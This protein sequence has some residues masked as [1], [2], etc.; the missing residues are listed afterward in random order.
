VGGDLRSEI[1]PVRSSAIAPTLDSAPAFDYESGPMGW[2]HDL[3]RWIAALLILAFFVSGALA[4]LLVTRL[5]SQRR[6][7]HALVDN[8]V[9][10]WIFSATLAI[11]AITVGLTAVASWSNAVAASNV[12]SL[13]AAEIAAL[14]RDLGGYPEPVRAELRTEL[15]AYLKGVIDTA[16]PAQRRGE[17][18][19]GGTELLT[20]FQRVFYS[21]EPTTDGQRIVHAEALRA[22]NRLVETRRQRL[23]AVSYAVPGTLWGVVLTG[24]VLAIGGSYVFSIESL[25]AHTVMT[26]LLASMIALLVFFIAVTD[27]PYRG[28]GG[29]TSGAYELVLHDLVD[30]DAGR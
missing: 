4:G 1:A 19:P 10:G 5:W 28:T 24:A 27:L 15:R 7:M 12:A 3:P 16:W 6:G 17:I 26:A 8:G 29:V 9:V 21:F 2:L 20:H 11:Y 25:G 18:P 14:Y 30:G 23:D 22:F 13:E